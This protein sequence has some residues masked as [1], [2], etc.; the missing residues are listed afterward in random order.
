MK[1]EKSLK[2]RRGGYHAIK[3][4]HRYKPAVE[5][6]GQSHEEGHDP[7][8]QHDDVECTLFPQLLRQEGSDDG[9]PAVQAHQ[10]DQINRN[11]HVHTAEIVHA[12][13]HTCPELPALPSSQQ[14][15]EQRGTQEHQSVS[16]SQIQDQEAC[17]RAMPD[18]TEH[19]PHHKEIPRKAKEEGKDQDGH[20]CL[21]GC[22]EGSGGRRCGEACVGEDRK[23]ADTYIGHVD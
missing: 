17:N 14:T 18:T 16:H 23:R 10:A 12:F 20:S 8:P 4:T 9:Q 3:H 7:D 13:A 21:M 15:E 1:H 19:R 5:G 6:H 22:R 11:V 2:S